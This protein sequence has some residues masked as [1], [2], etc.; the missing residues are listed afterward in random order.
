MLVSSIPIYVGDPLARHSFNT[1][2][3]IDFVGL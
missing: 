3:Y 1:E 2:S